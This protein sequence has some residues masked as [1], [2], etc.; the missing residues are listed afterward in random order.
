MFSLM[1]SINFNVIFFL[2]KVS[3]EKRL[4]SRFFSRTFQKLF[5]A[6]KRY[7]KGQTMNE[8][9]TT[10]LYLLKNTRKK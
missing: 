9:L 2:I 3:G 6:E 5:I 4:C 1:S 10:R 7:D 8:A